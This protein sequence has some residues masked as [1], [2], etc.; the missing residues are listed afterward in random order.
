MNTGVVLLTAGVGIIG[1]AMPATL[2][3]ASACRCRRP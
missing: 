1:L 2:I 3:S